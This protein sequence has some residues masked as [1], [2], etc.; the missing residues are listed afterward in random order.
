L[1][2]L[3]LALSMLWLLLLSLLT[4]G[5]LLLIGPSRL[6]WV[7]GLA[8]LLATTASRLWRIERLDEPLAQRELQVFLLL[9]RTLGG[10]QLLSPLRLL[11]GDVE[12]ASLL[13][14]TPLVAHVARAGKLWHEIVRH[15]HAFRVAMRAA[16]T[17]TTGRLLTAAS[18]RSRRAAGCTSFRLC[19]AWLI[20]H[21]ALVRSVRFVSIVPCD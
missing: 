17:G 10:R 6:R 7:V 4:L 11:H 21:V 5:L 8:L 16:A 15:L 20:V 9:L 3:L 14:C 12:L 2:L 13:V 19:L 18:S 1:L